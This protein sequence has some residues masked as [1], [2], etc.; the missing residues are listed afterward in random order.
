L[1]DQLDSAA[2]ASNTGRMGDM[3]RDEINAR[4]ASMRADMQAGFAELRLDIQKQSAE[5]QKLAAEIIK[6]VVG[7]IVGA[8]AVA[9]TVMTFVLNNAVPTQ[10]MAP[11][12]PIPVVITNLPPQLAPP[13]PAPR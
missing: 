5:M 4:F 13:P 6:W 1:A 11:G 10:P 12:T 2:F 3:S 7:M 8:G 9:I